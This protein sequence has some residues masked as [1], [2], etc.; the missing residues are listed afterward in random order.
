MNEQNPAVVEQNQHIIARIIVLQTSLAN[1]IK[2]LELTDCVKSE[3]RRL[4]PVVPESLPSEVRSV[5]APELQETFQQ[6]ID[7]FVRMLDSPAPPSK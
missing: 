1:I 3:L 2:H 6:E 5:P 7:Y 4:E